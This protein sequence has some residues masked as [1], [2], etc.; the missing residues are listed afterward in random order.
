MI[1]HS[2]FYNS[3]YSFWYHRLQHFNHSSLVLHCDSR[4]HFK[5]LQN[6][7]N[8]QPSILEFDHWQSLAAVLLASVA[9][10]ASPAGFLAHYNVVILTY[11]L[12]YRIPLSVLNAAINRLLTVMWYSQCTVQH[13]VF[14]LVPWLRL[15]HWTVKSSIHN[16]SSF[17]VTTWFRFKHRKPSG[18]L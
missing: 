4:L 16:F 15:F 14:H 7:S 2:R 18:A 12:T 1:F 10:S 13:N 9:E 11:L 8:L 3:S 5:V 17:F 6:Y